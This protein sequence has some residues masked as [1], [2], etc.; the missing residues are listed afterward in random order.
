MDLQNLD[1]YALYSGY[2]KGKDLVGTSDAEVN[3]CR[4]ANGMPGSEA[5]VTATLD[6]L[7]PFT[8]G[9]VAW[10]L[11]ANQSEYVDHPVCDHIL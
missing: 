6:M 11:A 9:G 7:S 10:T 2:T 5:N 8:V 3:L 4:F 1:L